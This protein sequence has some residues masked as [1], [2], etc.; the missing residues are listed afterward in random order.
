MILKFQPKLI[1]T[2]ATIILFPILISLGFWQLHRA[3]FKRELIAQYAHRSQMAPLKITDLN[4]SQDQ[5][6]YRLTVTGTFDNAH[7]L[8][9]DN[10]IHDH[11]VG[12]E[13][14]TPLQIENQHHYLLVDRGW[15]AAGKNRA[16]LPAIPLIKGRQTLTGILLETNPKGFHLGTDQFNH[17]WPWRVQTLPI[18][19][20]PKLLGQPIYT[21]ILALEPQPFTTRG[22][23]PERHS[24]YAFQWFALAAT[25]GLIYLFLNLKRRK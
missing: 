8:L 7:S 4:N 2:L 20:L 6:F 14:I 23:Q 21:Y 10:K 13:L 16:Q 11:Q 5:R 12:Y 1:P 19:Q 15:I 22:L 18:A 3:E 17:Q 9:I 24:G 25:L